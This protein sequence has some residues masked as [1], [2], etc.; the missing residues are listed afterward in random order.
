MRTLTLLLLFVLAPIFARAATI[1]VTCTSPTTYTDSTPII[2]GTLVT[3]KLYNAASQALLDTRTTCLF[4]RTGVGPGVYSHYVTASIGGVESD[5][6]NITTDTIGA[7]PPPKP[8][9]PGAMSAVTV[10]GPTAYVIEK[11][12]DRLV[13][14]P[15]GTVPLGTPCDISQPVLGLYV[16]PRAAVTW[17]GTVRSLA[18]LASCG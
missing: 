5:P 12:S 13:A 11:A 2:A 1:T 14:L 7:P 15:A 8:N 9:A 16:V 6:S 3:F 10:T 18:V 4:P 17:T